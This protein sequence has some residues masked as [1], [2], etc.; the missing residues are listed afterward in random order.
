MALT[1]E[2]TRED[3]R[4]CH[5]GQVAIAKMGKQWRD[6]RNEAPGGGRQQDDL[7]TSNAGADV[8]TG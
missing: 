2:Q 7:L 8:G 4:K 6:G 5:E 3:S 1:L